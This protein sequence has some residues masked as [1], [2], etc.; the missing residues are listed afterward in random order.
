M[1]IFQ[2][3]IFIPGFLG[4]QSLLINCFYLNDWSSNLD[5]LL[6]SCSY[7]QVDEISKDISNIEELIRF[8]SS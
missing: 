3:S 4:I 2:S 8:Y 5:L 6:F 7:E 1:Q